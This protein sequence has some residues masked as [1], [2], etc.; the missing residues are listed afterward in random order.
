[1][2]LVL[3]DAALGQAMTQGGVLPQTVCSSTHHYADKTFS[4]VLRRAAE[5]GWP[6]YEWCYKENLEPH[7]WLSQ[8]DVDEKRE[9]VT[10]AM[11]KSEYDLQDPSPEDRAI[12]FGSVAAMF[13]RSLGVFDG[14]NGQYIEVEAPWRRCIIPSCGE[15]TYLEACP[16]CGH[17]GKLVPAGSYA[18][19]ADW[20]RTKD[21]TVIITYRFDVSPFRLAAFE[22]CGRMAWPVM[23]GK[24]NDRIARY[25]G[26]AAHDATGL[27]DVVSAYVGHMARDIKMVGAGRAEMLT[28]YIAA[29]ERKEFRVPFIKF[30]EYDHRTA[31]NA[32]VYGGG[33]TS[34][35]PDSIAAGALAYAARA[36]ILIG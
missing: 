18:T 30:M 29:I 6:V 32:D 8:R 17:K 3:F 25:R 1:M 36:G 34:H 2:D 5:K 20:A 19:G 16:R 15:Y 28:Q 33:K 10:A 31:S 21:W 35:L 24:F 22:R 12:D 27:G 26:Q 9:T 11:W 4:E 23:V 13:D 14:A 7:G